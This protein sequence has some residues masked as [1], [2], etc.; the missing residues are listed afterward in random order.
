MNFEFSEEQN[1]LREQA[2]GF[3]AQAC[4]PALVRKVLNGEESGDNSLAGKIAEMGWNATVIPEKYD[5][6]GLSYLELCVI[7]EEM[8]RAVVPTSFS[9]SVYLATEALLLA[10]SAKQK[11]RWLPKL[12]TGEVRGT[13]AMAEGP[14]RTS[15][16]TLATTFARDRVKG[17][18]APV[19]DAAV[20][21]FAVVLV[22]SSGGDGASLVL[23]DMK[24][25][26]VTQL[27]VEQGKGWALTQK[28]LNR[29]AILFAW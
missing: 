5:G 23:V 13:F 20:A 27:L 1:L 7:A 18:K 17:S 9:S 15:P 12:A 14:G 11:S 3:L 6:L 28:L 21:D 10:G 16:K 22:K 25:K 29:A 4:S 2:R 24:G 8:G 19:A 26:G